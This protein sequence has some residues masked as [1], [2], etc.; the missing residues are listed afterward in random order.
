MLLEGT[1]NHTKTRVDSMTSVAFRLF[2]IF[3]S[4]FESLLGMTASNE[5]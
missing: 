4:A 2:E 5:T 1:H 3:I